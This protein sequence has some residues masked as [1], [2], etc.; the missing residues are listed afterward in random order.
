[1]LE[2]VVAETTAPECRESAFTDVGVQ[3][4]RVAEVPG[5]NVEGKMSVDD[6]GID[7]FC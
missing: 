2:S 6:L 7:S 5:G 4:E 1:M 3:F